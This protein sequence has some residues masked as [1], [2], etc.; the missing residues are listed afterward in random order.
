MEGETPN[1]VSS[2]L[3]FRFLGL[4]L[5][6]LSLDRQHQCHTGTKILPLTEV[7]SGSPELFQPGSGVWTST[8]VSS[9]CPILAQICYQF[10]QNPASS[11][12]DLSLALT[13]FLILYHLQVMPAFSKNPVGLVEPE[14]RPHDLP[15]AFPLRNFPP[16]DPTLLLGDRV[17]HFLAVL[18]A[19]PNPSLLLQAPTAAVCTPSA[20]VP[21]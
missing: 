5:Q 16:T 9:A 15:L 17:P 7:P 4:L 13:K 20:I 6:E 12:S 21:P 10:N 18:G 3:R 19:E 8:F 14:P 1:S 11:M 2:M